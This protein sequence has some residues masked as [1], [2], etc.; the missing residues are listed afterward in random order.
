MSSKSTLPTIVMVLLSG[1]ATA[2]PGFAQDSPAARPAQQ[3]M[4]N[5]T[6]P[7]PQSQGMMDGTGNMA[8]MMNMMSQMT[9]MMENCKRMMESAEGNQA[10]EK[11]PAAQ[12]PPG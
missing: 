3:D 7:A 6:K 8:S 11:P 4:M 1:L 9:R 5:G 10:P 2:S 12:T